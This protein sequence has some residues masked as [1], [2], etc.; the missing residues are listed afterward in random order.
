MYIE[1][2]ECRLSLKGVVK[3]MSMVEGLRLWVG[4]R[5]EAGIVACLLAG[6]LL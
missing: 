4:V 3:E 2:L 1:V 5:G 6:W